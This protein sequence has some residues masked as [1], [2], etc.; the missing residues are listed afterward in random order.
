MTRS[1]TVRLEMFLRADTFG[2]TYEGRFAEVPASAAAFGELS[3]VITTLQQ[4]AAASI[5]N[6]REGRAATRAAREALVQRLDTIARMARVIARTQPGF[7]ARFVRPRPRGQTMVL[8]TARAYLAAVEPQSAAFIAQ[9]MRPDFV[10]ALRTGI[11]SL[12]AASGTRDLGL[13]ARASARAGIRQA[14]K[15]GR[16]AIA[17]IDALVR[18]HFAHDGEVMAAW[19]RASRLDG[20][21]SSRPD[22]AET[23]GNPPSTVVKPAA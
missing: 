15:D 20:V 6:A 17:K 5:A 10:E 7:D 18:C 3:G 2:D 11:S 12:E 14:I 9:G 8:S 19:A 22:K 4:D 21:P 16:A 13:L 1:E 23:P